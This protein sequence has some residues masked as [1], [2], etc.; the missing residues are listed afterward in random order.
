MGRVVVTLA[1]LVLFIVAALV[2]YRPA[3]R[4]GLLSDDFTLMS[5]ARELRFVP[6]G[7]EYVRPL[8]LMIWSA[9]TAVT[10]VGAQPLVLH[11]LSVLLHGANASLVY[12][13]ARRL[14]VPRPG[15]MLAALFFLVSPIAVE[16][17]VWLSAV[18]DVLMTTCA[19]A[20]C[21][22]VAG[23]EELTAAKGAACVL[24]GA[25]MIAAKETGVVAAALVLL[26]QWAR[27]A[28]PTRR[29]YLLAAAL[30]AMAVA[31]VQWRAWA[32]HL[33]PR[34][35]PGIDGEAVRRLVTQS[36][37]TMIVPLHAHVTSAHETAVIAL[38]TAFLVL[39]ATCAWRW[40][41]APG[42][43]R[44]A[45]LAAAALLV[46]TAPTVRAFAV[47]DDLQGSR[48]LYLPAVFWSI[49][50][51]S[52]M[53][54]DW[55][56]RTVQATAACV[57]VLALAGAAGAVTTHLEPWRRAARVRQFVLVQLFSLPR[58]CVRIHARAP[59]N[60]EG[61]YVFR[62]GLAHATARAGRAF[63]FVAE[64]DA[65]PE[66]RV[67]LESVPPRVTRYE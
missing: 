57:A 56:S 41:R 62:N 24:L 9:V 60:F 45:L 67:N 36:F 16:P 63:E 34:L 25:L 64:H 42:R 7:W 28:P 2:L 65:A 52:A 26:T 58:S 15:S 31:Y 20:L 29:T 47:L 46:C 66:C 37:G 39:V 10:P 48:Y 61:A 51:G 18:S 1:R 17:V 8:P 12:T 14:G 53:L 27:P 55:P 23:E 11:V 33:D 50:L 21:A 5:W 35:V 49:A 13:L 22:I 40:R 54:A 32:G 59:D 38:K 43:A 6:A 4:V 3:L 19:L 30:A 44:L